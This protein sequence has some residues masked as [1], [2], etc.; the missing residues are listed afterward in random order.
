M[1]PGVVRDNLSMKFNYQ[2][3]G[4]KAT[5]ILSPH[6]ETIETGS[7]TIV[8]EGQQ[9][10]LQIGKPIFGKVKVNLKEPFDARSLTMG[11]TGFQRSQF[12][13]TVYPDQF[14]QAQGIQR[15]AKT[16]INTKMTIVEFP[17]GSPVQFGQSEY[18]F[19]IDLPDCVEET[20][21]C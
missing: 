21:M 8:I 6:L 4:K 12:E 9:T 20:L 11:I 5:T 19:K 16:L 2:Q 7:M 14:Q 13:P 3:P 17:E 18:S 15:L 10:S 1:A